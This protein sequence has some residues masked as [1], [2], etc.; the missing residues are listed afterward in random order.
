MNNAVVIVLF[1]VCLGLGAGWYTRHKQ[2]EE[3]RAE[4]IAKINYLS[5]QVKDTEAKLE[6]QRQVNQVLHDNLQVKTDR[7]NTFSND[8]ASLTANLAKVEAEAKSRAEAYQAEVARRDAKIAELESQRDDLTKRMTE[9]NGNITSLESK[10]M[11]TERQLAASEG[12]REFLLKELKRLQSEKAE[13][14]RQFNDLAV[15]RE[16]VRKLREELS[17][18]KRLEWLRRG[19]YGS[20]IKGAERLQRAFAD[21]TPAQTGEYDLDVELRQDGGTRV[22]PPAPQAGQTDGSATQ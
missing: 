8:V 17:I 12:D 18:A 2:A 9:L 11:E 13:L 15:L 16:Q 10:I 14:E 22:V 4:D 6:E 3:R 5:S 19:F 21:S 20:T 1:L 7:I